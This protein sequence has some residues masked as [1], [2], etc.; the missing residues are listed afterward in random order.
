MSEAIREPDLPPRSAAAL[1]ATIAQLAEVLASLGEPRDPRV[2]RISYSGPAE[3]FALLSELTTTLSGLA[4]SYKTGG[5]LN[6]ASE[7]TSW[8]GSS[9]S[10]VADDDLVERYVGQFGKKAEG[11]V[12]AALR[13]YDELASRAA[14]GL[15]GM[16][17]EKFVRC[18][19]ATAFGAAPQDTPRSAKFTG[20]AAPRIIGGR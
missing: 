4:I 7:A 2:D 19:V 5:K 8:K 6:D 9:R 1:R 16:S 13:S 3:Q 10:N 12:R 15:A 11:V 17:R 20:R 18:N 14:F